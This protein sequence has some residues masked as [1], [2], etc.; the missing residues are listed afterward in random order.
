MEHEEQHGTHALSG[1]HIIVAGAGI[2]GLSFVRALY[3]T[4]P[5]G[6]KPPRVTLYERRE[7]KVSPDREGYSISIRSDPMSGG[8][9]ALQKL[10]LLNADSGGK[11]HGPEWRQGVVLSVGYELEADLEVQSAREAARR[12]AS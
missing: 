4:W 12:L 10:C 11:H 2:A 3:R 7:K 6:L 8:M 5:V 1:K 9:Q